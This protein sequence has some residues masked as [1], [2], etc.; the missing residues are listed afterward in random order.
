MNGTQLRKI[1]RGTLDLSQYDLG[2]LLGKSARTIYEYEKA[3]IVPPAIAIAVEA[4]A[5]SRIPIAR[6][7]GGGLGDAG[8]S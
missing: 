5:S 7:A 3:E 6:G 1:R 2:E 4:L 8:A